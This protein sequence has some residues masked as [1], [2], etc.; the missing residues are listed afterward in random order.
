MIN[1]FDLIGWMIFGM[2]AALLWA[3][4]CFIM[5]GKALKYALKED[6]YWR[7]FKTDI[8]GQALIT[9]IVI[10]ITALMMR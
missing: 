2:P 1:N 9:V 8:A 5:A 4:N 6:E 7:D 10:V 3:V